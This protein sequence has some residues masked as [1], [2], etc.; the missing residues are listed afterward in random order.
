MK[1]WSNITGTCIQFT[2]SATIWDQARI[3]SHV[4]LLILG[5]MCAIVRGSGR[6]PS[7]FGKQSS[8][9]WTRLLWK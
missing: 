5:R 9:F 2:P 6:E 1:Y 3:S 4:V 8:R 7:I